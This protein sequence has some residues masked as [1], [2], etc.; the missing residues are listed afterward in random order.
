VASI[1][2]LR[3]Y[4]DGQCPFCQWARQ[5]IIRWDRDLL[6][7]F[8]DYHD[9][10]VAA[11]T[12]FPFQQLHQRMHVRTPGGRWHTGFFGWIA[13]LR[14][15]PRW[16]WLAAVMS[17]PPLRW[18]GPAAYVF[19]ANHRY[20]VPRWFLSWL[21]EPPPC[22]QSCRVSGQTHESQRVTTVQGR[23]RQRLRRKT[24]V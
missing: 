20:Q 11:E 13:I 4:D 16:R 3:I 6:L 2:Q 18:I 9:P 10:A 24:G 1:K 22:D 15:L 14:A 7:E 8:R 5:T 21:G 23:R 19:I 17:A 12:P